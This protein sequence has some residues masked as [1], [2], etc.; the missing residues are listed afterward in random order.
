M[1]LVCFWGVG[2]EGVRANSFVLVGHLENPM[3]LFLLMRGSFF[4]I[5]RSLIARHVVL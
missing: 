2:G 1:F 4:L 5:G 3:L